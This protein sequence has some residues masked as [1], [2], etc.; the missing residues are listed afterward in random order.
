MSFLKY[1][2][3][4]D[5]TDLKHP[6]S[7]GFSE[8]QWATYYQKF[9]DRS[10]KDKNIYDFGLFLYQRLEKVRHSLRANEMHSPVQSSEEVI[11]WLARHINEQYLRVHR[12]GVQ[13]FQNRS[14]ISME[15]IRHAA[16]IKCATGAKY[17]Q[18]QALDGL[19]DSA[20]HVLRDVMPKKKGYGTRPP[21]A[22][23]ISTGHSL[24]VAIQ[25]A[26]F[27]DSLE[28]QWQRVLWKDATFQ[29]FGSPYSYYLSELN[30]QIAVESKIDLVR[31]SMKYGRD[32]DAWKSF[33]TSPDTMNERI[34]YR[35]ENGEVVVRQLKELPETLQGLTTELA[36]QRRGV[37][38]L[39]SLA[40][41]DEQHG[42]VNGITVRK[43]FDGWLQLSFL[44]I[45]NILNCQ[46]YSEGTV[47]DKNTLSTPISKKSLVVTLAIAIQISEFQATE[48][49][50]YFTFDCK[51]REQ[52]LWQRPVLQHPD[53][54]L[55]VWLPLIAFHP[56]RLV[57]NWA[58]EDKHL[59]V[60]H[61]KRG[62]LFESE[63]VHRLTIAAATS[64]LREEICILGPQLKLDDTSIGDID[65][66]LIV[67]DAAV[68]LECRNCMHPATP[69]EFW[70]VA[71]ELRKKVKQAIQKRD[72]LKENPSI[73]AAMIG[74]SQFSRLKQPINKVVA[75]V[76]S[77]SYLYEGVSDVEPYFV[78]VD[79][80]VN[81][82]SNDTVFGDMRTDGQ[83]VE[84]YVDCFRQEASLG[85]EFIRAI[86][87]PIKAEFYKKCMRKMN[88]PITAIDQTEPFGAYGEWVYVPP[89][90]GSFRSTLNN[91]S[92]ASELVEKLPR[93]ER[94]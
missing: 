4:R 30:A 22:S 21:M 86:N 90:I 76:L 23:A 66:L 84:L 29:Y 16:V 13:A 68:V 12:E 3:N 9:T 8:T 81:I 38:E 1:L 72:H 18:Q 54:L 91:C 58:K 41:M 69:Y 49:I 5:V 28:E 93:R 34:L 36:L 25:L 78:H 52:T 87:K 85:D 32:I 77:N 15:E 14:C 19:I 67:G 47:G 80:L 71:S 89:E 65:A 88:F 57:A 82:L 48:L 51:D 53:G 63:V 17:T 61:S 11:F 92:F 24:L 60:V 37:T 55:L 2:Q 20:R 7:Y 45:Q 40:L 70:E 64:Q 6:V 79:T 33:K 56:M 73:L 50:D 46:G 31:R 83:E 62:W 39:N 44:A 10:E 27:Y 42:V 74:K 75:V 26:Q 35:S 43:V 94:D 59:E